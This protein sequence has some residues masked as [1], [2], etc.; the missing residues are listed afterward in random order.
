MVDARTAELRASEA[1]ILASQRLEAWKEAV[2]RVIHEIKN[3][4]T[5][6]GL[7]AETLKTAWA[8]DPKRFASVFPSA[9]D[10]ILG[11]VSDLKQLIGEFSRF[12]RLPAMRLERLDPNSLVL[13]AL[14]PYTRTP[15][16]EL[17]VKV[18]LAADAPEVDADADQIKRVL[19]NVINNALEAMGET[20]GALR[21][22]T[23]REQG[24]VTIRI[25]DDGPGVEDVERIFEPHYTTKVKG[26]GLGLAIAKQIVEE[27]GGTIRAESRPGH[28]TSVRIYL[29][30][31]PPPP[32]Q[33]PGGLGGAPHPPE[34][35]KPTRGL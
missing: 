16:E 1:K 31:A 15:P 21:L 23:Q 8:R 22:F 10:M 17:R 19:L 20:G 35:G 5:P 18:Q 26:T 29:P 28:G 13:D 4:L 27:H 30:C 6:V 24:G 33:P 34:Q 3:P 7:A 32:Q 9:I 2:E 25:E 12:S 14:A 11:A